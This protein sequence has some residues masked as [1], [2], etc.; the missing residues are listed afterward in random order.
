M[1]TCTRHVSAIVVLGTLVLSAAWLGCAGEDGDTSS[2]D[3]IVAPSSAAKK[4][5]GTGDDNSHPAFEAGFD[6]G[7][8]DG[9]KGDPTPDG[10]NVCVDNDDPGSTEPTAHEL[11]ATDDSQNDPITVNGT[12]N[13]PVD[14]DMYKIAVADHSFHLLQPAIE[15]KTPA[16]EMCTFIKC[17]AGS[18][19]SVTCGTGTVA[20]K[21][22]IGTDGCCATGPSS[23]S[24]TWNC[25][26]TDDSATLHFRIRQSGN[27]CKQYAF[28]YAF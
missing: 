17:P 25:S 27:T 4:D 13:G 8:P 24:P 1:V 28:S 19:S 18:T 16:V 11:K 14:V 15:I 12:L 6:D 5:S 2:D 23:A 26:G 10:G 22:D 9:G 3:T 7:N 21:S 20:T